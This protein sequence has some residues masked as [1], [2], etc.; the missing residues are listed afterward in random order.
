MDR[1]GDER[2]DY[3]IARVHDAL[4]HDHRVAELEL[5]VSLTGQSVIVSGTVV[6]DE[7]RR[8]VSD[9]I[10]ELLPGHRVVNEVEVGAFPESDEVERL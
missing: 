2:R 8:A 7:Q 6:S 10:H 1:P 9:V 5:E 3:L 4:S